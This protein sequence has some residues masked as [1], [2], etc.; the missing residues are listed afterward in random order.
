[1]SYRWSI[2]LATVFMIGGFG[3]ASAEMPIYEVTGFPITPHQLVV[4]GP[5]GAEQD[6][7]AVTPTAAGMPA[8]PHQTTVLTPRQVEANI[9]REHAQILPPVTIGQVR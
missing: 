7:T 3:I 4:T 8:S 1:M 6:L 9:R 2:T 5:A